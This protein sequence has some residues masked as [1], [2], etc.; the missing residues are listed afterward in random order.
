MIG[1]II[2]LSLF[3][4]AL[5]AMVVVSQQYDVYQNTVNA[6]S[7]KDIDRYSEHL[8]PVDPGLTY[9]QHNPVTG[10]GGT[11]NLY[12]MMLSNNGGV[13]IQIA[14]IYI[15]STVSG[16]TI[17]GFCVLNP[18]TATTPTAYTFS[19]SDDFLN[20]GELN[21]TLRLW[22]PSTITLPP[23]AGSNTIW[24]VTA[25]ARI[26]T[27]QWPFLPNPLAKPGVIPDLMTGIMKI[28]YNQSDPN[29]YNSG[30][31]GSGTGAYC[32]METKEPVPS[33]TANPPTQHLYFVNPWITETIMSGA[34]SNNPN[35]VIY[36]YALLNNTTGKILVVNNGGIILQTADA[37]NEQKPF[38]IGA[39]Y[40]ATV[41]LVTKE[42]PVTTGANITYTTATI[43]VNQLFIVIFKVT[44]WSQSLQTN[45]GLDRA[46][47]NGDIFMGTGSVNN[48]LGKLAE[49][50]TY[51][52]IFF[53]LEG[54]YL[55][56]SC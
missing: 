49:D 21:H 8:I 17:V 35:T 2:V 32:H 22:L 13:G 37:Y 11:C 4:I 3:L 30:N 15:N 41:P 54:V 5:V 19:A 45:P 44:N 7:Q 38:F 9:Y 34:F 20:A 56:K 40:E 31:E 12:I 28:A 1:G 33:N 14:R 39:I 46:A 25:R 42:G 53:F 18:E 55:K 52:S 24:I 10:C 48:A 47:N 43:Q 26:F 36:V 51:N 29:G 50:N 16:C 23:N 6:M 27:F